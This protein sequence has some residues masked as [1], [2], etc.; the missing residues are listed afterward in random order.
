M[1]RGILRDTT[2][3]EPVQ[4]QEADFARAAKVIALKETEH[5]PYMARLHPSWENRI[6]YWE[7]GDLDV[8]KADM[9]LAAIEAKVLALVDELEGLA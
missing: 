9:T 3:A 5:R 6:S 8:A 1:Q 7:I 4:V 2:A